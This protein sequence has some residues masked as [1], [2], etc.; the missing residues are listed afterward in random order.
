MW[1]ESDH[2]RRTEEETPEIH[3]I[4]LSETILALMAYGH[5]SQSFPWF[6]AP[7]EEN[8]ERAELLL[9]GLGA[10][11]G[12]SREITS[13]GRLLAALPVHPRHAR[14]L[15]Q[16]RENGCPQT[17][18]L[19]IALTQTRSI[20][21]STKE[22]HDRELIRP[23]EMRSDFIPPIRAWEL[24]AERNFD[25]GFCRG[26][27]IHAGRAREVEKIRDQFLR[28]MSLERR[29]VE[30]WEPECLARA[31][32]A[33]YPE[34]VARRTRSGSSVYALAGGGHGELRR[35]SETR[36]IE[37][38][39]AAEVEEIAAKGT[40]CLILGLSTEIR[41][42]WLAEI[43]PERFIDHQETIFDP[44]N[45]S[46][47]A[48][49]TRRFG[50]LVFDEQSLGQPD[51]AKA[52]A[53]LAEE[54]VAGHL[55]LKRWNAEVEH[56]IERVNFVARHCPECE[57]SPL[58]RAGR[59]AI[60]EQICLGS[61]NY[62]QIKNKE[63]LPFVLD[64]LSDEQ[65]DALATLAPEE[66]GLPN[67]RKPARIRYADG[68]ATMAASIQELYGLEEAPVIAS[69]R[70]VVRV[71]ALAPNGRTAQVTR[72]MQSFWRDSYPEI[73]KQLA[74]RYPKHDWR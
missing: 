36:G 23:D 65:A 25:L 45:R 73:R 72:D 47:V 33:G 15:L 14:V 54:I 52:A 48:R 49:R 68:E 57:I 61:T 51:P 70:Y 26:W 24:A 35:G 27:N 53:L 64:W 31:L 50:E 62:R 16:G 12:N 6:D 9:E 58:D 41:E 37:L 7:R 60:C 19:A 11:R 3:R 4:D 17:A 8:L 1:T 38:V 55:K 63:V 44:E 46:V 43:F 59:K 5:D 22:K 56:W 10:L 67:R 30:N 69:G 20:L 71:E 40:A 18:A 21:L 34:Q 42:E 2:A 39:V 74:G 29:A 66:H 28:G 32:L 13:V